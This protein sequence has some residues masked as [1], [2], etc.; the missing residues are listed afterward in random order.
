MVGEGRIKFLS[1]ISF[2]LRFTKVYKTIFK[3]HEIRTKKSEEPTLQN[4]K[5]VI[6]V[7]GLAE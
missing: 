1:T 3:R 5:Q 4:I 2:P 6:K 7:P